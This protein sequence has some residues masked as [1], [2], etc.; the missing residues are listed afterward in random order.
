MVQI[1]G[2][3]QTVST[4]KMEKK[5]IDPVAFVFIKKIK[6]RTLFGLIYLISQSN[7]LAKI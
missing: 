7:H 5:R 6:F 4:I 3:C 2:A 1:D